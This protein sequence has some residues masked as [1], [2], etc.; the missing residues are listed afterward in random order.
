MQFRYGKNANGPDGGVSLFF[1]HSKRY[2]F[3]M[4]F[5][6]L[7]HTAYGCFPFASTPSLIL[8]IQCALF[9]VRLILWAIKN[10]LFK[11]QHQSSCFYLHYISFCSYFFWN[12]FFPFSFHTSIRL[13]F[14]LLNKSNCLLAYFLIP[15]SHNRCISNCVV[16]FFSLKG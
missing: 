10:I 4:C 1:H 16:I 7:Y 2:S 9:T 13:I 12:P 8:F 3:L 15:V 6:R 5:H 14:T 11:R